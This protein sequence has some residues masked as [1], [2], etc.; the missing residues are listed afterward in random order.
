MAGSASDYLENEI[1]DHIFGAAAWS[2]PENLYFAL[3]T[4]DPLDTGLGIAEPSAGSY[5]R[6]AVVNNDTNFPAA[7]GG[8]KSNGAA[9]EFVEATGSWGT[10]SHFAIFDAAYPSGNML[11]HGDLGTPKAITTG[12][13]ARFA[14]GDLDITFG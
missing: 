5:T 14:I 1:L 9:I 8:A 13:T 11:A 2:A 10:I 4:A 3:S 6:K 7:T 12:D